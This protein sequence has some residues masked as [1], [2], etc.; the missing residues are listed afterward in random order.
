MK[1]KNGIIELYRFISAMII[2]IYHSYHLD[3]ITGYPC[4]GGVH[5]CRSVFCADGIFYLRSFCQFE[6]GI[7]PRECEGR[8]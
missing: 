4:G 2:M 7:L 3:N 6:K 1:S 8:C 5:I